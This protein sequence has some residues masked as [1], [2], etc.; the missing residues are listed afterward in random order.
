MKDRKR[1]EQV[2]T[3][4]DVSSRLSDE[5]TVLQVNASINTS[6]TDVRPTNAVVKTSVTGMFG[7]YRIERELG[8]GGMG[9]VYLAEDT[10]LCRKVALKIPRKFTPEDG[11][12]LERF[13]RE[14]RHA[15]T[16]R[17]SN[18]C[19][20]FDVGEIDGIHYLTMAFI[21]GRPLSSL[22]KRGKLPEMKHVAILIRKIALALDEAHK[23]GVIHRDLKPSNVMID[24]RNEPIVMDFGLAVRTNT[25]EQAR[26]TQNGAVL[27]TPAYMA[28]EQV[29]GEIAMIGPRSDIYALGVV[30]YQLLTGELPFSGPVMMVFAQVLTD[31]PRLPRDLRP[32]VDP[33]LENIC[34][35]MMMKHPDQRY[36]SMREVAAELTGY[37]KSR[38]ATGLNPTMMSPAGRTETDKLDFDNRVEFPPTALPPRTNRRNRGRKTSAESTHRGRQ[39]RNQNSAIGPV[40]GAAFV[41]ALFVI[42]GVTIF[43][44]NDKLE[45]QVQIDDP[46]AI[47]KVDN[48]QVEINS[49]GIG[50][51]LLTLKEHTYTIERNDEVIE[52]PRTFTVTRNGSRL[53]DLSRHN[54]GS[55]ALPET[56]EPAPQ[57]QTPNPVATSEAA[58]VPDHRTGAIRE[59]VH[60]VN[61]APQIASDDVMAP[62]DRGAAEIKEPA[63]PANTKRPVTADELMENPDRRLAEL[64]LEAGAEVFVDQYLPNGSYVPLVRTQSLD[65]LPQDRHFRLT[66]IDFGKFT[67]AGRAGV[68]VSRA[69]WN[70]ISQASRLQS[71][72]LPPAPLSGE[73][74]ADL[75]ECTLISS[76]DVGGT[77][78]TNADLAKLTGLKN[79]WSLDL[80]RT[81][82]SGKGL[83]ILREFSK[84][85][86]LQLVGLKFNDGDLAHLRDLPIDMLWLSGSNV[87]DAGLRFLSTPTLITLYLEYTSIGDQGVANIA[88]LPLRSL[89]LHHTKVTSQSLK[90][91]GEMKTL[92]TLGVM[93]TDIPEDDLLRFAES[94]PT[95]TI[96]YGMTNKMKTI[97]ARTTD[98][99]LR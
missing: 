35:R 20:V 30:F 88:S 48:Q 1:S 31:Q 59:P 86:R 16:L 10:Q 84:L 36:S 53:L 39:E 32:D 13:Y 95:C 43:L 60:P 14:G 61:T 93:N 68:P 83:E 5:A 67:K 37:L 66:G 55:T 94:H 2:P 8:K 87:T 82:V 29:R 90:H 40:I 92:R 34:I 28:P 71:L 96:I 41:L 69:G 79:L 24:E 38:A 76:L 27:G 47:V 63:H 12:A 25:A 58:L 6:H 33:L 89:L 42:S 19:P 73:D 78:L 11:E 72:S 57:S 44:R 49:E 62:P 46:T 56:G 98:D 26:L 97:A 91:L 45:I 85:Q 17:H 64:L 65:E 99:A 15:A 21:P 74:V 7:R 4:S 3:R 9:V 50:N 18:L 22:F 54:P 70:A 81:Q 75:A 23:Q 52:G 80:S 77:N 51:V